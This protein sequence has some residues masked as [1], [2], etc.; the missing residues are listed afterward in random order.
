VASDN[1]EELLRAAKI[2]N[3]LDIKQD[4]LVRPIND[5]QQYV[6]HAGPFL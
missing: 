3:Y 5:L 1:E 6:T 2:G 4:R